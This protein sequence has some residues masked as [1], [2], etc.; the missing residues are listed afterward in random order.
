MASN[1]QRIRSRYLAERSYLYFKYPEI[2]AEKSTEFYL[3][4]LE[5]IEISE[6][7][8]ANITSY[9]LIGRSGN[10]FAYTGSKSREFS[11]KFN[12]TLPNIFDYVNNV[13]LNSQF[14]NSFRYFYNE[15]EQAKRV[16]LRMKNKQLENGKINHYN[17][18]RS[19][20]AR[21][22]S[23]FND[24]NKSN[25]FGNIEKLISSINSI[26][27]LGA[28]PKP[29]VNKKTTEEVIGYLLLWID[30]IRTSTINNSSDTSLGPPM[31]YINHGTMY[32]NIP[33]VCNNYSIN[34]NNVA[35][36][37]LVSMSPRQVTVTMSLTENRT[38]NFNAFEPFTLIEGENLA[39]WE[40][41]IRHG[42]MDP[43]N[44]PFSEALDDDAAKV[45]A[46]QAD[47]EA[48][49]QAQE[50]QAKEALNDP[51]ANPLNQPELDRY[52]NY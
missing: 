20:L 12:I 21:F 17:R 33:C 44:D 2:T 23:D 51:F 25:L 34:I 35:G 15:R 37:D 38:G 9:D 10:L 32:N 18:A 45:I 49:R 39:G 43:Y 27:F 47:E 5:N 1:N 3:P 8:K 50:A 46:Q 48:S 36:Y 19:K 31:I 7:Q 24:K 11:L 29:P 26:S 30:V 52:Y 16:A 22:T 42:T 6:S 40:S 41:L 4:M 28:S 14:S 13:G